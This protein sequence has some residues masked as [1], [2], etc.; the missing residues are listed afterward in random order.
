MSKRIA[1]AVSCAIF[2]LI[3]WNSFAFGQPARRAPKM[4]NHYALILSD[5]P[6]LSRFGTRDEAN[7]PAGQSYRRNL[8]IAQQSIKADLEARQFQVVGSVATTSNAIFVIATPDRVAELQSLR[9]VTAVIRMRTM[10]ANTNRATALANAPAAWT[11][12]GGSTN[13]GKGVKIGIIDTGIDQTHPAFQDS[14]LSPPAGFP[15]CTADHNEDCAYTNGKVIVARSYVRQLAAPSDPKNPAADSFPDDYSPRDREGHGTAVASVAAGNQNTGPAVTFMGM[16]PKAFLGNYK[17]QGSPN[18]LGASEDTLVL[19]VNDA[20]NDGMDV[21]NCSFGTIAMYPALATGAACGLPANTPCDFVGYNYEKAAEGGMVIAVAAGNDGEDSLSGT[22]AYPTLNVVSSPGNAP[23]VI[24]VGGTSNSHVLQPTV[25]VRGGPANLQSIA[26]QTSDAYSNPFFV[27]A[28]AAPLID[29]TQLGDNGLGCSALPANSLLNA[30]ALIERGTCTFNVKATVAADAGALGVILYMADGSAPIPIETQDN[31]GNI[32]LYGPIVMIS[33]S[34]GLALKAYIDANPGAAALVDPAGAEQDIAAYNELWGYSPPL[35]ANMF[36]GFSSPGPDSGDFAVKP[37]IVATAGN[38]QEIGTDF[39]DLNFFAQS[40]FYLAAQNYDPN[41]VLYSPT[42]YAAANGTSFAAPLAAGAAALVHQVHPSWTAAQIKAAIVN[43]SA[44]D[45]T[46]DEFDTPVNV[47]SVGAGRLD[48]NAAVSSTIVT[49]PVSIS[50]G[51]VSGSLPAAQPLQITNLGSASVNLTIGSTQAAS[52]LTVAI[53]KTSLTLA[54]GASATVNVSLSGTVPSPGQ[55]TGAITIQGGAVPAHVP[56]MVLVPSTTA[57]DLESVIGGCFLG[58]PNQDQGPVAVKMID[59]NGV[60]LTNMPVSFALSPRNSATIGSASAASVGY[61]V[62][63]CTPSTSGISI[64]CPTDS[65]GIAYAEVTLGSQVG[66]DPT[67]NVS[68]GGLSTIF[69]GCGG[70]VI[71]P[72]NIGGIADAANGL[73]NIAPG[74]YISIYGTNL[75]DPA[76]VLNASGDVATYLPLPLTLDFVYASFD[77]PGAYD[78]KPIDYNGKPGYFSF[79]SGAGTQINLQIPWELQGAS[80]AQVKVIV[81]GFALSN[82]ITVPLAQYSPAFFLNSG[83]VADAL[84]YPGFHLIGAANP[85]KRG[86]VIQLYANGLGPVSN[87]PA[88]GSPALGNPLSQ[89]PQT[90]IVMIGGQQ[91]QVGFSGLAPGFPG[92]YQVNV[93]VPTN[94]ATGNQPITITIGGVTSPATVNGQQVYIPVQ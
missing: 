75:V 26:A 12:A 78:G 24:T 58:L 15:K 73:T 49:K 45:V 18:V 59:A 29:V 53:D 34:D 39:S 25:N 51:A 79:V 69:G 27:G 40:G 60:P 86:Q 14:S 82:V 1:T 87:Q 92:L 30:Y 63:A 2:S 37:D 85:A 44:Q 5:A 88:S 28:S 66:S 31:S 20:F 70:A 10:H 50:F 38:D 61:A 4:S 6:V 90:P 67:V 48:A 21:V 35:A 93:T 3:F 68:G 13:A 46:T 64:T 76:S 89:T 9:G 52:G 56:Y 72:P 71:A 65:L 19:A 33:N 23:S 57:N 16:A 11:V 17:V 94:A 8:E 74:S 36:L 62:P 77:V 47:V 81:D 43:S 7:S 32:P 84:D 55:V 41:G 83:Y 80:S 91:A 42:R 22:G 54:A